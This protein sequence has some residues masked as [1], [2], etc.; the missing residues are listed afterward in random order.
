M[1]AALSEAAGGPAEP[2]LE[3]ARLAVTM[4]RT[5]A[6]HLQRLRSLV[7]PALPLLYVP[8]LFARTHGLRA[9]RQIAEALSAELGF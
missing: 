3:A 4:R 5:R 6:G 7:D 9:T 8:Y 2:V 1:A